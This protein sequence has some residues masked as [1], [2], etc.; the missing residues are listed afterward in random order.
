MADAIPEQGRTVIVR[1][2]KGEIL[3]SSTN[4]LDRLKDMLKLAAN[5]YDKKGEATYAA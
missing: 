5:E 3:I 4:A 1:G 2:P